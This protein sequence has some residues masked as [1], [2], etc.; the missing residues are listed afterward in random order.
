[1]T[2]QERLKSR[3]ETLRRYRA[4]NREKINT[5][6]RQWRRQKRNR[7]FEGKVCP[8]CEMLLVDNCFKSRIYCEDCIKRFKNNTKNHSKRM[9]RLK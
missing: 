5:Y 8:L 9:S 6:R 7:F 4:K 3:K 1:M 2:D